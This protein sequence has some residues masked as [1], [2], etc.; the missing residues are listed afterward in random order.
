M[1]LSPSA[2]HLLRIL[3]LVLALGWIP[4][5][6][7]SASMPVASEPAGHVPSTSLLSPSNLTQ[8][9]EADFGACATPNNTTAVSTGGGAVQLAGQLADTFTDPT[10]DA[11]RWLSG[12]WSGGSYTPTLSSGAL[13]VD[14]SGGAWVRSRQT[15]LAATVEG[16]LTFGTA[17]WQHFGFGSDSFV[18]DQYAIFSTYTSSNH[19][20]A[21]LN[22]NSASQQLVDLGSIPSGSHR[23]RI[24]WTKAITTDQMQFFLDDTLVADLTDAPLP[25]L[26]IY[27]S[28]N[29]S[30]TPLLADDVQTMPP[31]AGSGTFIS[32]PFDAGETVAWQ[33]LSWTADSPTNT[34]L[35]VETRTSLDGSTWSA[36]NGVPTSGGT[37]SNPAGRYL[38]YRL[39]LATEDTQLSPLVS[40]VTAGY[41]SA[42]T[43]PPDGETLTHTSADNFAAC[44]GLTDTAMS[45]ADDGA[46]RLSGGLRDSFDGSTLD[47]GRWQF[48]TWSTGSYLPLPSDGIVSVDATGGAWI[49]SQ[50]T[51]TQTAV[52]GNMIFG[53]GAYQQFGFGSDGFDGNRYALFSTYNTTTTLYARLNNNG[54]EQRVDLGAIPEGSHRYRITWRNTGSSDLVNYYRDG[55]LVA[56]LWSDPLPPLYVYLSNNTAGTPL[57]A[58]DVQTLAPFVSS[59]TFLSCPLDAGAEVEWQALSWAAFTP[60]STTLTVQA[61]TSAD[62][63]SW[64]SWSTVTAPGAL[65]VSDGRYLQYRLTL[66]TSDPQRSPLVFAVAAQH[67]PVPVMPPPSATLLDVADPDLPSLTLRLAVAPDPVPVGASAV[68]TL[69]LS[70]QADNAAEDVV[71]SVPTPDGA[72]ALSGP[73]I[74]TPATGWEW[75]VGTLAAQSSIALTAS[76]SLQSMPSG[77]A[78]L[79]HAQASADGLNAPIH[80]DRGALAYDPAFGPASAVY[81]PSATTVLTSTDGAITIQ[82]PPAAA[83]MPLTLTINTTPPSGTAQVTA[84]ANFQQGFGTFHLDATDSSGAAVSQFSQPLTLTMRYTPEQ[85]TARG[86]AESD[87]TLFWFDPTETVTQTD[88]TVTYGAWQT[89]PIAVDPATRTATALIDHFSNFQLS[90]GSSPSDAFLPSVQGFQVSSFTGA[91]SYSYP[92]EVPAGPAGI[93]PSVEL[94]YSSAATDGDG[95]K[96]VRQQASWVGK[97]WSLDTGAIA[98]NKL[99]NGDATYSLSMGG[100]SYTLTRG[101]PLSGSPYSTNHLMGWDWTTTDDAFVRVR[102]TSD[103]GWAAW[104][105]DGTRYDFTTTARW[106]WGTSGQPTFETYK[107]LLTTVTDTHSNTINYTYNRRQNTSGG[108]GAVDVDTWPSTITWAGGKYRVTFGTSDRSSDTQYEGAPNQY[109]NSNAAPHETQQLNNIKVESNPAGSWQLIRQ[110]NLIYE[111]TASAMLLSDA[112]IGTGCPSG[113]TKC[114]DTNYRKLTLKSIQQLGNNGT[115]ALPATTFGYGAFSAPLA[116]GRY[117]A[118][119]SWNRLTTIDN[120]QGGIVT[121]AYENV[122]QQANNTLLDNT[123]R[124][125]SRTINDGRGHSYTWNYSYGTPSVNSLGTTRG[126]QSPWSY[127]NWGNRSYP[128][129][130]ALYYNAFS[131]VLVDSQSWLAQKP[132]K[133]FRGHDWV[134][135][136]DPNGAQ[137]KHWFYQGAASDN[138]VPT[139]T[140]GSI[141]ADAC[142][143]RL[144]DG[145][146]LKGKEYQTKVFAAGA[147]VTTAN[148]LQETDHT[149]AVLFDTYS[150]TPLTGLWHAFTAEKQTDAQQAEGTATPIVKTTKTFYNTNCTADTLATVVANYG[151]VGCVQELSGSTLVRK[152]LHWYTTHDVDSW[153]WRNASNVLLNP[154]PYSVSYLVDRAYQDATYDVNGYLLTLTNSFYDGTSVAS[155]APTLGDLRRVSRYYDIPLNTSDTTGITLHSQDTTTTYDSYGNVASTATYAGA[156]TRLFNGSTTTWSAPGAGSAARTTSTTYDST[157]HALPT[158]ASNPLS[159]LTRATYDMRMGTLL[160]VTGP[161]TS[162]TPTD[163]SAASYTVPAGEE[164]SCAIYDVFGRMVKLVKPGD[165]TT[166][167]TVQAY[168]YDTEQPFRYRVDKRETVGAADVRI[169]QQFYDGL[170]RQIQTKAESS[171]DAQNIVV[172]TRYDGLNHVTEASQ[173]RYVSQTATTFYQYTNPGTGDLFNHTVTTYDSLGRPVRVKTPDD[174]WTE[175]LYGLAGGMSYHDVV[176]PNRHRIQYRSD[177]LGR[178]REV[179]EISGNCGTSSYSWASCSAPYTTGWAV[180]A[181]S[182]YA[183]DAL[184]RLT[185][186]TDDAGN[187]TK[188]QYDSLGRKSNILDPSKPAMDDPDMGDWNYTYDANGNLVTQTDASNQTLWFGYDALSRLTQ[189]RLT[190]SSGTLLAQYTYDQTSPTNKGI[191]KRT[192]MTAIGGIQS[193][194]EYDARGRKTKATH[195]VPG[196]SGT[197]VFQWAYDSGD[198]LSSI[199]YPAFPNG[200]VQ[201]ISYGY[202][203]AWR[204]ARMYTSNWNVYLIDKASYTA[205][206]QP[207]QWTFY[208]GLVQNYTYSSSMQ[209]LS[210]LQV[211]SGTPASIFDRSYSYDN[212]GNVTAITDNKA[213]TNNQSYAYDHRDRLTSWTLNGTTQTYAYNEIGNLTSKAG[214]AYTYPAAGAARPHTP[215]S[216]GGA[217]YAYDANGNL[218][219]GSGRTYTWTVDNLPASVSQTSGSESYS[220]DADGERVK[221]VRGS[222]STVYLEGLWEEVVGGA[223]KAYYSFNGQVAVMYT[224][225][226]SAFTYLH[227]DHLGSASV[228]TDSAQVKTQQEFDPWGKVRSTSTITQTSINFTGQRLDGTGLLY[229][230]ARYYDPNLGRFVSADSI[231]PGSASGGM[232]GIAYKPLTIDFHEPGFVA[233]LAKENQQGFWFQMSDEERQQA[234]SPWGPQNPQAL[235]RYS[236]VQNNPL[237]YTD[238]SGHCFWDFCIVEG[239]AAAAAL[240]ALGVAVAAGITA[241]AGKLAVDNIN[242]MVSSGSTGSG[243]DAT[244]VAPLTNRPVP[245]PHLDGHAQNLPTGGTHPYVPPKQKGNPEVVRVRGGGYL[246]KDGNIWKR[247]PSAHGGEHW[248]VNHPD[249]SHTNVYPD[250]E[251]HQGDDNFK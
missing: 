172:D 192:Q 34:A 216:V 75:D 245:R 67:E 118:G 141:I 110:Y 74:G 246:D 91:A 140:G 92:I 130:A 40:A 63:S 51:F 139:A 239:T 222:T 117:W 209:R 218:T 169:L 163:C 55:L 103:N 221:V 137:T 166:H 235:N 33:T 237:R 18:G 144:R 53:A 161:N 59:G 150:G 80:E 195:T 115:S 81:T 156:G 188:I 155:A 180:Y 202:D 66:T 179:H 71:V 68:F 134:L 77:K 236:Y 186:V 178:L 104:T 160:R 176:D 233:S 21:R 174:K 38:Q 240:Y 251:V 200:I 37:L 17:P 230:H 46:L 98:R 84:T 12:V 175:H 30:G 102:A 47:T 28:N 106:G 43:A 83:T 151:N 122:G 191:G 153:T 2:R 23:Y 225:S 171:L 234:G 124:V 6:T 181:I 36:W 250:G 232:D 52:E 157:Y 56:S 44:D 143:Q 131:N 205:L 79:F 241:V 97:G 177:A 189:K 125:T 48:G 69:T 168:Y 7:A 226:P 211:G 94:S 121:L 133:E 5:S 95:G 244:G 24:T 126:P 112:L 111:T 158:Q 247:D 54:S 9:T 35:G 16:N 101:D 183:Y 41:D 78:L 204:P 208:N 123:R 82:A 231:V 203:Q 224:S 219:G 62:A 10:L 193:N 249:K 65:S 42:A 129:S 100:Q 198:R 213:S 243:E 212:G 3:L 11:Q 72:L 113:Q 99:P 86:L 214:T 26:Y 132:M 87:L 135:E 13:T 138:C 73:T 167:P 107:W 58:D 32:C 1:Q 154:P 128:T 165:S 108:F 142:F 31:F 159:Q 185:M 119:G 170:G 190:S 14:A 217:S 70:N 116:N 64:S 19:L 145:E 228:A 60:V 210:Q 27:L 197:R 88:D 61:R 76:L 162:G 223:A 136:T 93:K 146:F 114:G 149:F 199:T 248:D 49:R 96:R 15:F 105:K 148:P 173:A 187:Q 20:Y 152:T 57:L 89:V 50:Q 220:Y 22:N 109:P 196:L 127:G 215:T 39:T 206:D 194:W 25:P 207:D 201:T 90:D 229:Y 242:D 147:N 85:L 164:S 182:T 4:T 45:E 29:T 184:D 8:T 227:N 238:P 120:G